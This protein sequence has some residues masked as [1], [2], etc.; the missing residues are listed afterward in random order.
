MPMDTGFISS[1]F[2]KSEVD[3]MKILEIGDL[4]SNI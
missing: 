1:G 4:A 3:I 2:G